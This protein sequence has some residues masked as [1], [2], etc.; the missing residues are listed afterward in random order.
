MDVD[1]GGRHDLDGVDRAALVLA[2]AAGG[3]GVMF[4]SGRWSAL[5]TFAGL[6]LAVMVLAFHKPAPATRNGRAWLIRAAFGF[7][8]ALAVY[9]VAAWPLQAVCWLQSQTGQ[10]AVIC[11]A[12]A[13]FTALERHI[14]KAID[15]PRGRRRHR[16]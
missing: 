4:A 16:G 5:S 1:N 13:F 6:M 8:M 14:M 10:L 3:F 2:A 15:R 7:A 11:C 9:I 12:A